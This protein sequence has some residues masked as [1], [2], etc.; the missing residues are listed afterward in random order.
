MND[1]FRDCFETGLKK[2]A[3]SL[4][5]KGGVKQED[6][7]YERIGRLKQK[8][9]SIHRYFDIKCKIVVDASN[10]KK[11]KGSKK[12]AAE[13]RIVSSISWTVKEDTEIN[14]RSGVYF[15][16]TSIQDTE[17]IIWETYNTIREIE[18]T[19]RVLKTDLDLRPV[20]HKR[21]DSS[22]AHLHLGLLAYWVVNTIRYQLKKGEPV[23]D[24]EVKTGTKIED[25]QVVGREIETEK[26]NNGIRFEWREIVR[27]MSAQ[28]AVTT[29]A[30]N[31][32]D[33]VI[34]ICRCTYPEEKAKM[35]YD[36]LKYKYAPYKKKKSVVHKTTFE[37]KFPLDFMEF[38]S[39]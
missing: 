29:L 1:R 36:K 31:K 8:Y 12:E 32:S 24:V 35:I 37:K 2:I 28:K 15:L 3:L 30:Q 39:G 20:Y 23:V 7:V 25:K 34:Q 33:E 14:A 4:D 10:K 17:K 11:G 6:K 26:Q 27:I 18:Y 21:D 5:K 22:M 19:N 38:N 13:R 16:R 9:P